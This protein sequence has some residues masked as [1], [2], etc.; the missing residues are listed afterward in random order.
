[1]AS[2]FDAVVWIDHAT[3]DHGDPF[4]RH[5]LEAMAIGVPVVHVRSNGLDVVEHGRSGFVVPPGA[6]D[7]LV[8]ALRTALWM[9]VVRRRIV[10]AARRR[11]DR[12]FNRHADCERLRRLFAASAGVQPVDAT[13]SESPT[14]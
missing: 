10:R 13:S 12:S 8:D 2:E 7:E 11:V 14:P 1:M 5:V 3:K 9:D 4:L 6:R